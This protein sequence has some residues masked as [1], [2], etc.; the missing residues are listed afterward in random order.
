MKQ[1]KTN[2]SV[3]E[4]VKNP[5]RNLP[6][7]MFLALGSSIIIYGIGTVVM[8]GVLPAEQLAGSLTPVSDAARIFGGNLGGMVMTAAAFLSFFSVANAGILGASRYPLAMGRDHLKP[9]E[10]I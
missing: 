1:I 6:L 3:P 7:G 4:E 9:S 8:V 5:E 10:L 2:T